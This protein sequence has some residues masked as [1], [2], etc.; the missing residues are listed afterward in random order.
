MDYLNKLKKFSLYAIIGIIWFELLWFLI[1]LL[2]NVFEWSF[3]TKQFKD[4]FF[5][6]GIG[7][8][9]IVIGFTLL[10]VSVNL[11]L[12]SSSLAKFSK[13]KKEITALK[14]QYFKFKYLIAGSAGIIVFI[15]L[16]FWLAEVSTYRAKTKKI[17][18]KLYSLQNTDILKEMQ[19]ILEKNGKLK[20]AKELLNIMSASIEEPGRLSILLLKKKKNIYLYYHLTEWTYS[21]NNNSNV[22]NSKLNTFNPYYD[23]AKKFNSFIQNKNQKI[24]FFP[25]K[26]Y[27][28][29]F[30]KISKNKKICFIIFFDTSRQINYRKSSMK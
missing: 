11:N 1:V 28:R 7:G 4:L 23:E 2:S 13:P 12:I 21:K 5:T 16:I 26:N 19:N 27:I 30:Y 29:A 18:N 22:F 6:L 15:I 10:N 24:I 20:K 17:T 3:I 8:I 14:S 9:F 25:S